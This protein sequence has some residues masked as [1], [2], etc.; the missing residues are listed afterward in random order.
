[1]NGWGDPVA[2][3]PDLGEGVFDLLCSDSGCGHRWSNY[4]NAV[5]PRC[6][7][8]ETAH[9]VP[10]VLAFGGRGAQAGPMRPDYGHR[11]ADLRCD[12]CGAT[13]VGVIGEPCWWCR[14]SYEITLEHQAE[15]VLTPPDLDP[16]LNDAARTAALEAWAE[17]LAVAVK[18]GVIS[19]GE[20]RGAMKREKAA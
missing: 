12:Q 6:H 3:R 10:E 1:M 2:P 8:E 7:A 15:L 20:A 11:W 5:C 16:D 19:E 4:P 17:R 9:L 13:W 14:R 18:A